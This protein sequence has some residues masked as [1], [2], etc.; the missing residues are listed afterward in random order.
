[1]NAAKRRMIIYKML[2]EQITVEVNNLSE[3]LGVSTMTIRRDLALFERQGLVVTNYGGAYLNK[4]AG[5]EP[6]FAL[7]R[8]Q[9]GEAKQN[10]ACEAANLINDGD[11]IV[12]DCGTTPL[13]IIKYLQN[14]KT[15]IITNSWPVINYVQGNPK[16]KLILAPGVYSET[17]AGV[18][19]GMTIEFY[20]QF[21][22]DIVFMSTQGFCVKH[23]ATVPDANDAN[24]KKA[25][26]NS[27][28]TKILV[29]DHSKI[30]KRYLVCHAKPSDF[31]MII[32]DDKID[33]AYLEK[34]N[35][36]CKKVVITNRFA[37]EKNRK[38]KNEKEFI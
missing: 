2:E 4:G 1:M 15:T 23:G 12:L 36:H 24:V 3:L 5:V 18:L 11:S 27:A 28:K 22:A 14:K 21:C 20:Q 13:Q 25:V 29:V 8:G 31:D 19:S 6:S 32:T 35:Q 30:D 9:M 16:I 34:M 17:S 10:I 38:N 26:M 37:T 7:K 33:N